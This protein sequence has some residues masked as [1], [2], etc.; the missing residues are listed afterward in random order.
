M[1]FPAVR[2]RDDEASQVRYGADAQTLQS[3]ALY[4][5]T[6]IQK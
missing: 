1:L 4:Q 6:Q 3:G 5:G 2:E